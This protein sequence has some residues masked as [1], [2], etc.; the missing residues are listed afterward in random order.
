MII[1]P[2]GKAI[3]IRDLRLFLASVSAVNT[4]T[5]HYLF[6]LMDV[7]NGLSLSGFT[8]DREDALGAQMVQLGTA[9]QERAADRR[10]T[11]DATEP[12]DSTAVD[13]PPAHEPPQIPEY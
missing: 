9:L 3:V 5:A 6:G 2:A 10:R 1:R 13:E 4:E 11:I 7:N 12:G 8:P